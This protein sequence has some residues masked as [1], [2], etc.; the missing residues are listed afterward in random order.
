[1]DKFLEQALEACLQGIYGE[2]RKFVKT[3]ALSVLAQAVDGVRRLAILHNVLTSICLLWAVSAFA[4]GCLTLEHL[5]NL[6]VGLWPPALIFSTSCLGVTTLALVIA[7]R[8][9]LWHRVLGLDR[10]TSRS[11]TNG[12]ID[13]AALAELIERS[14]DRAVRA[15]LDRP[16]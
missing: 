12:G 13:E 2:G 8:R 5:D 15:R 4:T 3:Q 10:L 16:A 1:M 6:R 14:V 7:T 11:G 9:R